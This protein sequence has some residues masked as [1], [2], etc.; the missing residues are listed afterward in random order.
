MRAALVAGLSALAVVAA[1]GGTEALRQ[2]LWITVALTGTTVGLLA[3]LAGWRLAAGAAAGRIDLLAVEGP[4][5]LPALAT[6]M[7]LC[8]ATAHVALLLAGV[9]SATGAPG[10][11]CLHVLLGLAGALVVRR[12]DRGLATLLAVAADR[13]RRW[14]ELLVRARRAL[15]PR[16]LTVRAAAALPTPLL[17]R[18]PPAG[19]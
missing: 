2:P 3:V 17:G 5:A 7:V 19:S 11:L 4:A 13:V 10:T 9:E 18:A 12:L 16:P 6:V 15:A 1:H 8:Q 14:L